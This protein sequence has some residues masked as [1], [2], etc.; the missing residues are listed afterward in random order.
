MFCF[1][2]FPKADEQPSDKEIERMEKGA[3]ELCKK[4]DKDGDGYISKAELKE[5]MGNSMSDKELDDLMKRADE[6]HDGK[7]NYEGEHLK[8]SSFVEIPNIY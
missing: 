8:K 2:C 4:F 7:V 6:N 5:A 1:S 3:L